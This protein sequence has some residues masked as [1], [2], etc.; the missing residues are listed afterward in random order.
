MQ[1][2][3]IAEFLSLPGLV[4]L[5]LMDGRS[6][7]YFFSLERGLN[8]QQQQALIEGI[9]QV[10][11]T[12]PPELESFSFR[13]N[14]H[15]AHIY[16]LVADAILLVLVQP[17]LKPSQYRRGI[18]T[19]RQG[20]ADDPHNLVANFRMLAGTVTLSSPV[21]TLSPDAAAA[22]PTAPSW[23][24]I[25][26]AINSLSDATAHFMGKIVV[27]N[28]WKS[29]RPK[30]GPLDML[31]VERTGHLGATQAGAI[32]PNSPIP[33]ETYTALQTWVAAFVKRCSN[34]L[35]DYPVSV[36]AKALTPQQREHL[37]LSP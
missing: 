1:Q 3:A 31:Q 35:R 12:T 16:R 28:T 11:R 37:G 32:A 34:V 13:F 5:A 27:A 30:D 18:E 24:D 36:V 20:M 29:T 9:E 7:P 10:V 25:L 21:N 15:E 19:L 17:A 23:Q 22:A 33:P 26:T 4:G 2:Q 8:Y 6:R 14:H